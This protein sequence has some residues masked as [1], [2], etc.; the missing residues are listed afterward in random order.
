MSFLMQSY[1]TPRK[2]ILQFSLGCG[3]L[4]LCFWVGASRLHADSLDDW[5]EDA[6]YN[7]LIR[8]L[9]DPIP[10]G[11]DVTI[12]LVEAPPPNEEFY[13]PQT[14][15]WQFNASGDS[16]GVAVNFNDGSGG[17]NKGTSNHATGQAFFVLGNSFSAAPG[18]NEVTVY[19]ANDYLDTA[20]NVNIGNASGLD[21][22]LPDADKLNFRVQNFSWVGSF[23]DANDGTPVPTA[24]ELANDREA[25]RRFD[26][27]I[28][29]NNITAV[30]GVHNVE[31]SLP[32]L[33]SHSYNAI[34]VGRSSGKH[35]TGFTH[36]DYGEIGRSKPDL[37]ASQTSTSNATSVTSSAAIFLHS[38]QNVL[39]T[40][41]AEPQAMKA[42]L[43]AG[44]TKEEFPTWSQVDAS[45]NWRPLDD[46][47]GAGELNIYNSYL[48]TEGGQA[49]GS[50]N[51]A[52]P[53]PLHG[54]DFQNVQ[55]GSDLMYEFTIPSG[56]TAQELSVVLTWNAIVTAPFDTGDPTLADLTLELLNSSD[57]IVELGQ[58]SNQLDGLSNSAVDNVEH[59]YL[60]D[61]EPGTYT[62]KVSSEDI[63]S[64]FG[65]AWR[66]STLFDTESADFDADGDVDGGDFL[67]WQ[68]NFG[69]LVGA[70]RADGD[71]NGDGTVD[72]DDLVILK[73]AFA[74]AE[75]LAL[76]RVATSTIPEPATW[77]MLGLALLM[78]ILLRPRYRGLA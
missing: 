36:F 74:E 10:T 28:N 57:Q 49:L 50:S 69:T 45:S 66:T 53:A 75:F 52:T 17:E 26:F 55:P 61:L 7:K 16:S 41:A 59:L 40:S 12:A 60:N 67:S 62:L 6:D 48:I 71:A 2:F 43:M 77:L 29:A 63:A 27:A 31:T 11:A 35:S 46:T 44:A 4:L 5:L 1:H 68:R 13:F 39:G 25:L 78:L 64:D 22:V 73:G 37:V 24:T 18:A 58:V 15:H 21:S 30:V 47:F 14:T 3:A 54:W 76:S 51:G 20:L 23:A 34:A 32:N 65:L 70:T 72:D 19:E 56:S 33:L 38:S 8:I 42:I 9:P